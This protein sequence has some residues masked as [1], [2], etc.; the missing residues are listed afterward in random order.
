MRKK[1]VA[2]N[3]KMNLT[4]DEG[5][6]LLEALESANEVS[7]KV[8]TGVEVCSFP[9]FLALAALAPKAIRV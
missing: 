3:W 8:N 5:K 7:H 6:A 9:G 4:M 1:I 2:G